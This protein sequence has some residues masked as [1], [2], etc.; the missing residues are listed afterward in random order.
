MIDAFLRTDDGRR[1]P[2]TGASVIGRIA[3]CDLTF[4]VPAMSRSHAE[5]GPR[6]GSWWLRDLGS[7]NGTFRNGDAVGADPV[8]VADGDVLVFAGAVT[9]TFHD[10]AATPIAP[11]IGRLSGVWLD[12]DTEAV[13]V[14]ATRIEPPLSP[15]Q[16]DLLRLLDDNIGEIVTRADIVATV[17]A[18]VAATGVSDDAVTALVKRLRSRLRETPVPADHLQV[19]KGRGVRLTRPPQ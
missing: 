9:V 19:V 15:R 18:D 10:P 17:W 12:P 3:A 2:L 1:L 11:R 14:D 5:I 4:D 7:R 6:A 8:R 16:L 13:W